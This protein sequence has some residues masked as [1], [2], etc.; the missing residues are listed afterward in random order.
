[1]PNTEPTWHGPEFNRN[2][3]TAWL[4]DPPSTPSYTLDAYVAL[5]SYPDYG[6]TDPAFYTA[7]AHG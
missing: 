5:R 1:M 2:P 3:G 4:L 7:V 6:H